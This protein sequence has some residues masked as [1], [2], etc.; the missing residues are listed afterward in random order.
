MAL[1]LK[2]QMF[3]ASGNGSKTQ[4]SIAHGVWPEKWSSIARDIKPLK[5]NVHRLSIG[6]EKWLSIAHG[7][8]PK[9]A[10]IYCL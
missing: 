5:T 2:K 1:N 3:I 9:E 10:I 6:P 7:S 8:K 4:L